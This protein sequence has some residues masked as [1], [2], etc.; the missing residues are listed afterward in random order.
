MDIFI[1]NSS[2]FWLDCCSYV[3]LAFVRYAGQALAVLARAG[4]R[5]AAVCARRVPPARSTI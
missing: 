4:L 3:H 2:A 5:S 1:G